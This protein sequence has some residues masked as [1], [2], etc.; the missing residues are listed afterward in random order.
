MSGSKG[1][2]DTERLRSKKVVIIGVGGLGCTAAQLLA[3]Q[4]VV[5]KLVDGDIVEPSNLE[6]QIMFTKSDI[7]KNKVDAA[8]EKISDFTNVETLFDTLDAKNTE[9]ILSD[10]DLVLDCT[11]NNE[12]RDIIDDYCTANGIPWVHSAGVKEIGTLYLTDPNDKTRA[13]YG[14]FNRGKKGESACDVGVMNT[15]VSMVGAMA[16]KLAVDHLAGRETPKELLRFDL[17]DISIERIRVKKADDAS[18]KTK[19]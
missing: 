9:D 5:L 17:A 1:I 16:A 11:D 10:V 8:K 19:Q 12:T 2:I 4:G 13:N 3:R 18:D 15:T 7:G 6:R 14:S